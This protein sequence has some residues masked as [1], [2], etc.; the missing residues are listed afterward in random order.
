MTESELYTSITLVTLL[1]AGLMGWLM[2]EFAELS[3]PPLTDQQRLM[4]EAFAKLG[5]IDMSSMGQVR[6]M[7]TIN[8]GDTLVIKMRSYPP[9]ES[10]KRR[11]YRDDPQRGK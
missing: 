6:T 5:S 4:M 3:L 1:I 2:G 10:P 8:P 9:Y 7:P 11:K